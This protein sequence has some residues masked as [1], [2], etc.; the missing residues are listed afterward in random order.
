MV[1]GEIVYVETKRAYVM[2]NGSS[3]ESSMEEQEHTSDM[4]CANT[5]SYRPSITI[6]VIESD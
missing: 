1:S 2:V 5:L 3:K 4:P 6:Y